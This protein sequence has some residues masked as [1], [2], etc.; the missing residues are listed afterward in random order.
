MDLIQ[1]YSNYLELFIQ[2]RVRS[3]LVNGVI[4]QKQAIQGELVYARLQAIECNVIN[5]F[6]IAHP[7]R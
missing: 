3:C 1:A 6:D 7:D 2:Q 5:A 4:T